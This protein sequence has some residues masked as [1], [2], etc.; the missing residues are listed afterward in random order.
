RGGYG[1]GSGA[2]RDEAAASG[3]AAGSS[4]V[5]AGDNAQAPVDLP[6][7]ICGATG[8]LAGVGNYAAVNV[9]VEED[10]DKGGHQPGY[11]DEDTT[12]PVKHTPSAETPAEPAEQP[13]P[14]DGHEEAAPPADSSSALAE[15]GGDA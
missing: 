8:N 1:D 10:G 15:T 14:H 7:D 11:G 5:G 6:L 9:C 4:G 12:P 2:D 13:E 3:G